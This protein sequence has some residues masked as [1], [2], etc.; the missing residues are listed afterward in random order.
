[1]VQTYTSRVAAPRDEVFRWHE[2]PGALARITPPWLR[3]RVEREAQSLRDGRALMR[4]FGIVRWRATH[5]PSV[6]D[7]PHVFGAHLVGGFGTLPIRW[8]LT[9]LF[10]DAGDNRTRITDR[11]ETKI[12]VRM[13]RP[14][15]EYRH[16]QIADEVAALRRASE[17]GDE[18]QVIGMTGSSGFVGSALT[19]LLRTSGFKV[20]RLVRREPLAADERRWDPDNPAPD[21]LDGLD[22]VVHLA[23]SP[24]LGRF[25]DAHK[26]RI[27]G[28]RVSPTRA[29]AELAG[30]KG[31]RAFVSA[32]GI[33]WYGSDRGSQ[34]LDES[35]EP[36]RGFLAD[37]VTDWEEAATAASARGVRTVLIRTGVAVSPEGG[38]LGLLGPAFRVGAGGV[39]GDGRQ[40]MPWIGLDDLLDIYRRALVDAQL[41]GPVNAVAPEPVRNAEF[42]RT[43]G[44]IL[45]RPTLVHV[46]KL[47][48]RAVLG[49]DGAE[50]FAL[51]SQRVVPQRLMAVGHVF[52]YPQL[53]PALRHVM[54]K[55]QQV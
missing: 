15:F 12:P 35:V 17:F 4:L 33:G 32:S 1:M 42:T 39:L 14:V 21:L 5:Q 30:N 3:I 47:A 23:G 2:R 34:I 37:V 8:A 28:S 20:V 36:G 13:L 53:E 19:A 6:Y 29:L 26:A 51:V 38:V 55:S 7:P 18:Q 11:V 50:E 31:L 44:Q 10:E 43:L 27:R 41:S 45:H 9:H 54:G 46:P 49:R 25:T 48:P 22:A 24:I 40:W 16:Q 52:R